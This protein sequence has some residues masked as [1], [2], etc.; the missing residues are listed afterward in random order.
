M[1]TVSKPFHTVNRRFSVGQEIGPNDIQGSVSFDVW[2]ERG[3]ITGAASTESKKS[4]GSKPA[5]A[6]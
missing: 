5:K 1:F 4:S 2:V 6:A 3:F